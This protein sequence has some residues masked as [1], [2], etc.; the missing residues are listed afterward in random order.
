MGLWNRVAILFWVCGFKKR[1]SIGILTGGHIKRSL[2]HYQPA[3]QHWKKLIQLDVSNPFSSRHHPL[4]RRER[5]LNCTKK[6]SWK[7][8]RFGKKSISPIRSFQEKLFR[9]RVYFL[10]GVEVN[11]FHICLYCSVRISVETNTSYAQILTHYHCAHQS[12]ET[13]LWRR[14][15]ELTKM[16]LT[17]WK[18]T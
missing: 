1:V 7:K 4:S 5:D 3:R 16:G 18:G 14:A 10:P 13:L 17:C 2:P 9:V 12:Q 6:R 8:S 15:R 11:C